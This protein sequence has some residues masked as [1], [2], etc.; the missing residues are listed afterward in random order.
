MII[1]FRSQINLHIFAVLQAIILNDKIASFVQNAV[2]KVLVIRYY[3]KYGI[4]KNIV[5]I[6]RFSV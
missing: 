3:R 5:V 6:F 1:C 2:H 4:E